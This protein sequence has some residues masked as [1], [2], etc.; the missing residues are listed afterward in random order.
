MC[1]VVH[2]IKC[3]KWQTCWPWWPLNVCTVQVQ[4]SKVKNYRLCKLLSITEERKRTGCQIVLMMDSQWKSFLS[5]TVYK[6]IFNISYFFRT[7][8]VTQTFVWML[9][10]RQDWIL[11]EYVCARERLPSF[12]AYVL[13]KDK[14]WAFWRVW[15]WK[16]LVRDQQTES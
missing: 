2:I 6:Y 12:A 13:V 8:C 4:N 10:G 11:M 3:L 1:W 15:G 5:H 14:E 7:V 9:C 16:W